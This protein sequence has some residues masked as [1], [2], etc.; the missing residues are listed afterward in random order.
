MQLRAT[1]AEH[2]KDS[3]HATVGVRAPQWEILHDANK[4]L[5]ASAKTQH[6]QT[7]KY[8]LKYTPG[9]KELILET[10]TP[11]WAIVAF[12]G[13]EVSLEALS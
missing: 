1:K 2:H 3:P 13:R 8:L 11:N 12:P 6:T 7:H 5:R 9:V 10:T 4:I